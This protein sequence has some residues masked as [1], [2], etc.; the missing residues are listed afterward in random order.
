MLCICND[1]DGDDGSDDSDDSNDDDNDDAAAD[2]Y[3]LWWGEF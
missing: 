2:V 1:D 3:S